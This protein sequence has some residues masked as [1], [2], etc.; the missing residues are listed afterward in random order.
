MIFYR[1]G[2][3]L[4]FIFAVLLLFGTSWHAFIWSGFFSKHVI[5][6]C[7]IGIINALVLW[8]T[9]KK[10]NH[11]IREKTLKNI[12]NDMNSY[13]NP[14]IALRKYESCIVDWKKIQS[15]V[16]LI[17]RLILN[18]PIEIWNYH[19]AEEIGYDTVSKSWKLLG[20]SGKWQLYTGPEVPDDVPIG[21]CRQCNHQIYSDDLEELDAK[22]MGLVCIEC[23]ST[24]LDFGKA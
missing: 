9:T 21:E 5:L 2:N 13:M 19:L 20:E 8:V 24:D 4:L 22:E 3:I 10:I 23:G 12:L 15:P 14:E 6:R 17:Y 18:H 7:F 11:L 16:R 1:Y